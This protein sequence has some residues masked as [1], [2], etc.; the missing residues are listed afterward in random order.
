MD[1]K[2]KEKNFKEGDQRNKNED[3]E[4]NKLEIRVGR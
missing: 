4:K 3:Q 2:I 1:K